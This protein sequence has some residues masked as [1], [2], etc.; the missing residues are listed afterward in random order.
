MSIY[1]KTDMKEMPKH[2]LECP[3]FGRILERCK[4]L[5]VCAGIKGN[6]CFTDKCPLVTK[7][8]ILEEKE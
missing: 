4:I 2:I 3:F 8:Q 1:I 5:K 6:V 7:Q